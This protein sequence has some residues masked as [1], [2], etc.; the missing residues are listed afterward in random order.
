MLS[1][2]KMQH[3]KHIRWHRYREGVEVN[4]EFGSHRGKWLL[5][6]CV[7]VVKR[8][9][10]KDPPMTKHSNVPGV[11]FNPSVCAEN[12]LKQSFTILN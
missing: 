1:V 7:S 12:D 2:L 11:L 9:Q 4:A 8:V 3:L 6:V 5:F 10:G